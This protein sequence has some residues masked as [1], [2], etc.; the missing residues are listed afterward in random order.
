MLTK[1]CATGPGVGDAGGLDEDVVEAA[2]FEQALDALHEV[3]A[4]GAADA[5]VAQF[6]HL[7]LLILDKLAIDAESCR[8][9]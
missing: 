3:L 8:S 1:V 2:L 5:A 9:H 4:H 6:D 7:I